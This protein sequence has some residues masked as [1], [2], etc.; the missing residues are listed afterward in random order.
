MIANLTSAIKA[1]VKDLPKL[2][3]KF[4]GKLYEILNH[5]WQ[6]LGGSMRNGGLSFKL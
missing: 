4:I 5:K 1:V 3:G 2:Y 6:Q